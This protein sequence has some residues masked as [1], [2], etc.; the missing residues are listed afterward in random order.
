MLTLSTAAWLTLAVGA[1]LVGL[2]KTAV[3]GAG[4]ISVA[5]FAAVLPAKAST[6]VLLELLM[7]GDLFAVYAYRAHADLRG[8]CAGSSPRC[9]PASS[10]GPCSCT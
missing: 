1:L 9:W 3:P 4:T 2:S 5:V 8:R 10:P 7:V 6:G